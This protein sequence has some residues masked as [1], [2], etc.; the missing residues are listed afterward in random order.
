[1]ASSADFPNGLLLL[2]NLAINEG[3]VKSLEIYAKTSGYIV[4]GVR[5]YYQ[6]IEI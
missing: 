4:L 1:M 2:N 5:F 3:R 6:S